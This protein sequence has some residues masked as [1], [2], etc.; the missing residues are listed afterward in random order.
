[1]VEGL[2]LLLLEQGLLH[3]GLLLQP[4][5]LHFLFLS[6]EISSSIAIEEMQRE[7]FCFTRKTR[8]RRDDDRSL[9]SKKGNR[10][11][12]SR[13]FIQ[14][15]RRG[16]RFSAI[17]RDSL[18]S[19]VRCFDGTAA[20]ACGSFDSFL[21]RVLPFWSRFFPDPDPDPMGR[22]QGKLLVFHELY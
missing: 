5:L 10:K 21:L 9:W 13:D 7:G 14:R 3:Q 2:L 17:C 1:M 15:E 6:R 4:L 20:V 8:G 22:P 11:L 19:R 18:I 16:W 12:R